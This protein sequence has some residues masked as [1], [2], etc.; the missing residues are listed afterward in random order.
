MK[1][2]RG[3]ILMSLRLLEIPWGRGERSTILG[4]TANVVATARG[5]VKWI[6]HQMLIDDYNGFE[7][8]F[9]AR[10]AGLF[11]ADLETTRSGF[12]EVWRLATAGLFALVFCM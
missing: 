2:Q 8:E 4:Q 5:G 12:R 1:L 10:F 11:G 3:F 6:R 7:S 9:G